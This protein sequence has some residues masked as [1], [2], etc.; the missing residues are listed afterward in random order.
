M[1]MCKEATRLMS[2]RIEQPLTFQQKTQLAIHL[3]MCGAC[4]RCDKQFRFLHDSFNRHPSQ[5][6]DTNKK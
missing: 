6:G 2:L 4:R 1:I 5:L 3:S